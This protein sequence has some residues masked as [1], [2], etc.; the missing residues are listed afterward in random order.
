MPYTNAQ[1]PFSYGTNRLNTC[2]TGSPSASA[3]WIPDIPASGWY[4]VYVSHAAY[5]NRSTQAHYRVYH[6]GG[7]SDY[8]LD[9]RMRRM[10]WIFIGNYY[11]EGG[12]NASTGKVVLPNDSSST[13]DYISADAVRFGGL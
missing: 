13:S 2:V 3:T 5:S 9:Q 1:D 8:Y 12:V 10:T 6:A 11:F 4:N 7:E